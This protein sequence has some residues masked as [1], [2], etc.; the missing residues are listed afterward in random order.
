MAKVD[1]EQSK[2][3]D[4]QGNF[5]VFNLENDQ[6]SDRVQFL[7]NSINDVL[8]Y[9]TH[10]VKA[11]SARGTEYE[12]KVGCLLTSKNDPAGTCPLCDFGSKI[13]VARFIPL[14]SHTHKKVM[15]WER[16]TRFIDQTLAGLFN[17][18]ISQGINPSSI[19][20]EVVRNG[21]KG[22]QSTTYALYPM[23]KLPAQDISTLEI[24]E[25]S[26][27]LIAEWTPD[28]M[29][30]YC[31]TGQ[32]PQSN[33]ANNENV[34]RRDRATEGS[35]APAGPSF[36]QSQANMTPNPGRPDTGFSVDTTGYTISADP[37]QVF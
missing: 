23:D 12:R 36:E 28:D 8:A 2:E 1:Y 37:T 19:V 7:M 18:L 6:D 26:G 29:R 17:R 33:T 16:G 31:A 3:F 22:D 27:S 15:L 13:K 14:Y 21:K 30:T 11:R 10:G 35:F 32:T 4:T 5:D 24:P 20:I 9:T 34:Q 25:P